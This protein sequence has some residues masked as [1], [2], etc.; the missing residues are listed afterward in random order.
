MSIRHFHTRFLTLTVALTIGLLPVISIAQQAQIV[1]PKNKYKTSDDVRLGDKAAAETEQ[2][3]PIL[4][5][6][7]LTRYLETVGQRL[8]NAIPPE[9]QHQEFNYRFEL[10]NASDINAFALPGGPMFVDRGMIQAAKNEGEVA[11]VMAHEISHVALRHGTAQA[12]KQGSLGNQLGMLGMI[13]GGAVVGGQAGAQLGQTGAQ[14]WMTKYSREYETQADLLG[15]RIM[16]AAGYDPRDLA[17]MFQTIAS[18][19]G[20]GAPQWL[21][22]HPDPGNRYNKINQEAQYLKVSGTPLK[23]TP[24]FQ[25]AKRKLDRMPPAPSMQQ[26]QQEYQRTGRVIGGEPGYGGGGSGS[27][28]SGADQNAMAGGRYTG[29]VALPSTRVREFSSGD[30]ISLSVPY[31]WQQFPSQGQVIFAPEGAYGDQGITHGAMMGVK[32]ASS[33]D[34]LQATQNSIN[35]FVRGNQYLRQQGSISRAMLSG[36]QAYVTRLAGQSEIT[37]QI[38]IVTIYSTLMNSGELFYIATVAP[39]SEAQRYDPAFRTLLNSLRLNQ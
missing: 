36:S 38:E 16:A 21:S 11:G 30:W 2:Q 23:L 5:D 31:N 33:R 32:Q 24:Q 15:A 7:A 39:Q 1:M 27:R 6:E 29:T 26:I 12:T 3:F 17:N 20:S 34:G 10:V 18:Q 25:Q 37:G 19:G 28:G 22:S 4:N 14:A 8:V 35:E 13:L 9:F